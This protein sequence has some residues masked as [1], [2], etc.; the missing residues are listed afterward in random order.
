MSRK[1]R[2]FAHYEILSTIGAGG[3]GEVF[4]A[5]D[6]KLQRSVAIKFLTSEF[7]AHGDRLARFVREARAASALSHPNILTIHEIGEVDGEHYIVTE[8]IE[9]ATLRQRLGQGPL[10]LD[11]VLSIAIQTADAL[12]SAH[13]GGITHRDI[14]P[15]NIMLRPDGYLKVLDFGLAKLSESEKASNVEGGSTLLVTGPGAFLGTVSYM[16]PEQARGKDIDPRSDIFSF[17]VVLYEMLAGKAPFPGDN[18]ADVISGILARDPPQLAI[19]VPDIPLEFQRIIDKALKKPREERYSVAKEMLDDLKNLQDDLRLEKKLGK[20]IIR[21][22]SPDGPRAATHSTTTGGIKDSILLTDF[23]NTTGEGIFDHTLRTALAISLA[24]SPFL[25]IYPAAKARET[26]TLMERSPNERITRE[27]GREIC[28][29]RRLKALITGTIASF[30]TTFVLTLEAVN[31][32]TGESLG[33][34]LEQAASREEVLNALGK[35]A[36]GLRENLGESLSSIEKYD[37]PIRDATTSSLDALNYYTLGYEQQN[38]GKM[39][40]AIP[41][42]QQAIEIDPGFATVYTGLAVAYANTGQWK[43][44]A[45]TIEKA[46]ELRNTVSEMERLRI[47]YLYYSFATGEIEK[48]IETLQL[49]DTTYPNQNVTL[50]KTSDC[51]ERIGE[52]EKAVEAAKEDLIRAPNN[53]IVYMNLAESQLSLGRYDEIRETCRTAFEKGFDG[54]YFHLFPYMVAFIQGDEAAMDNNL[55]W[56]AGRSDEYLSLGVQAGTAAFRGQWRRAQDFSRKAIDLA[57]RSDAKEVAALYAAEHALRIVFWSSGTGLPPDD[58]ERVTAVLRT[59]TKKALEIERGTEVVARVAL[60]LA[61]GG[62]D[63]EARRFAGEIHRERSRDTLVNGL[64][65]PTMN[66]AISLRHRRADE[67]LRQLDVAEQYEKAGEFYP[68]YIRA[69][70]YLAIG[71]RDLA[72][73]E[74]DKILANRGHAPLSALY[75]LAQLGKARALGD[76]T[77]YERFFEFWKDADPDMPALIAARAE[78][79]ALA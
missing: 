54:D 56:F 69:L 79:E 65:I 38:L 70:V 45:E 44:A 31:A 17:G 59:Q 32:M 72:V 9:G 68:Q 76:R 10:S 18:P 62:Q 13:N 30:G 35:A 39:L 25:D 23:E 41:Y 43:L 11:E 66:A 47:T 26:M 53:A 5:R 21:R 67:A 27:L 73:M 19:Y 51:L 61:V 50:N 75:P 29:R 8:F 2:K 71:K 34:Q 42:Y 64:W 55:A 57:V 33:R 20:L 58:D 48:A 52:S 16:S 14:K 22:S 12:A 74:F 46:H 40:E 77:E 49:W 78:A 24:Q 4:L 3:M 63:S 28:L 1:G 60:S 15:E 36:A 37:M 6:T 7:A